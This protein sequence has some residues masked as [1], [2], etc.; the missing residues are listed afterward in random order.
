MPGAVILKVGTLDD[1]GAFGEGQ[2]AIFGCDRQPHQ[3]VPAGVPI[4]EN[5]P[6]SPTLD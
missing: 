5:V 2:M 4:Y 6:G 1:P 3:Q